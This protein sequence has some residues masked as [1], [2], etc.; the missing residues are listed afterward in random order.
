MKRRL[1][2]LTVCMIV[3]LGLVLPTLPSMVSAYGNTSATGDWRVGGPHRTIN[4][5][6]LDAFIREAKSNPVLAQY[7]FQNA[8]LKVQGPAAGA[9]DMYATTEEDKSE[10]FQWWVIEGG[11]SADEPELPASF[12][13]FYN[14]RAEEMGVPA[15]LTD[16]LELLNKYLKTV[17]SAEVPAAVALAVAGR[18]EEAKMLLEAG[19]NPEVDARDWA[20]NGTANK[21]WRENEYS[22]TEGIDYLDLAF[23]STDPVE[24]SRLFARAW[25]SL[26]E[27][28]HLMAD[29]SC[30]PH[31]RND[32][33]PAYPIDWDILPPELR[34]ANP[35]EGFLKGDPYETWA[36]QRL[37][38]EAATAGLSAEA[39][40]Y[41]D[42]APD[43]QTL[44]K[45]L[46]TFTNMSVFSGETVSGTDFYGREV[47]S[48]NG[49]PDFPW[50][51]LEPSQYN[52]ETGFYA[53]KIGDRDVC[54]AHESWL[55]QIGWGQADPLITRQC[56]FSQAQLLIPAAVAADARLLDWF[57]P[58]M[59]LEITSVDTDNRVIKGT[60]IHQP[61][62]AHKETLTF[63]TADGAFSPLRLNDMAQRPDDYTVEID[64]GVLTATYGDRVAQNIESLRLAGGVSVSVGVNMGGIQVWSNAFPL[65]PVTP[66]PTTTTTE[67]TAI[68][69]E[70]PCDWVL[71]KIV[72]ESSSAE[73]D[74]YYHDRYVTI[75]D[76]AFTSGITFDR[77][78]GQIAGEAQT[79][80]TW[81]SP[82]SVLKAGSEVPL[83]AAC[84][85]TGWVM[86]GE[87]RAMGG[88]VTLYYTLGLPDDCLLCH[89]SGTMTIL[90][91]VGHN[92]WISK[93]PLSDSGEAIFTVPEGSPGQVMV[94]RASAANPGGGGQIGLKYVCGGTEPVPERP[95][96]PA[97]PVSGPPEEAPVTA[98]PVTEAPPPPV[99]EAPVTEEPV[100]DDITPE[101]PLPGG[102]GET[103]GPLV[104]S[105]EYD[106]SLM[107]PVAPATTFAYGITILYVDWTYQGV[108]AGT[109]YTYEW[110]RDGALLEESGNVLVGSSGHTFDMLVKDMGAHQPLDVGAYTYVA[111]IGGQPVVSGACEV[112]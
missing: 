90:N 99:T 30:P 20:I 98:A 16:H 72:Q 63:S 41:L 77:W 85:T 83:S 44:F 5:L 3:A 21:G 84:Q 108:N 40:Q 42:S 7:D 48:A 109:E 76:G 25:R 29:M 4:T 64:D 102:T 94:F 43:I 36:S 78:D 56:A 106:Y 91:T 49:M 31:V 69:P 79:S 34:N 17:G 46:A 93:Y 111:K 28:M 2:T 61:Y 10:P 15:Y 65:T 35:N 55:S 18:R 88:G 67:E 74:E 96:A 32:S 60:F 57:I 37:I 68:I 24:K 53:K 52:K 100:I 26:G 89:R 82:P 107:Q 66:T 27:T 97:P 47:H 1:I 58:R 14:P 104:F 9:P 73:D 8:E 50:P 95:L 19:Q 22:W 59:K 54:L 51:K 87:D 45:N 33:H 6:A 105:S 39:R 13:H 86:E 101:A 81:T 71:Q 11:Y 80:C 38:Q 12:R 112:K 92:D 23:D 70:G 62:G 103:F 75:S 110:Y